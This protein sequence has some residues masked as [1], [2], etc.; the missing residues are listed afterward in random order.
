MLDITRGD[1]VKKCIHCEELVREAVRNCIP[2]D[3][4]E[5][6]T[7]RMQETLCARCPLY[8]YFLAYKGVRM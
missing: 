1:I 5:E 3:V 6:R 7:K 2:L 4:R 8:D